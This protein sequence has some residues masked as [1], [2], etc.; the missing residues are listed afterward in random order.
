MSH[1]DCSIVYYFLFEMDSCSVAQAGVQW[2]DLSSLQPL[3]PRFKRFSCLSRLRVGFHHVGLAGLELLTSSDLPALASQS[4][5][6]T[7]G[8]S[9]IARLECSGAIRL[10]ALRFSVQAISCLSL[11]MESPSVSQAGVQWPILA[12]C[13][14]LLPGSSN[15]PASASQVAGITGVCHH[16]W[17][18]FVILVETGFHHIG[19]DGRELLTS[20]N[21]PALASQSAGITGVN[22]CTRPV[23]TFCFANFFTHDKGYNISVHIN[24]IQGLFLSPRLEYRGTI[25]A[26]GS[27]DFPGSSDPPTSASQMRS[28][29]IVQAGLELLG[30]S[31]C[32]A[33]ASQSAGI[34]GE[35]TQLRRPAV[36]HP[37]VDP[38]S[39]GSGRRQSPLRHRHFFRTPQ[40][41]PV[42][43]P[44]L[45]APCQL[46]SR[47]LEYV[48]K[49]ERVLRGLVHVA[50]GAAAYVSV[51]WRADAQ[52]CH[53]PAVHELAPSSRM[54]TPSG[55]GLGE[56]VGAPGDQHSHSIP[57]LECS[58][59]L[60]SLLPLL[61]RLKRFSCLSLLRSTCL[62]AQLIFVFLVETEFLHVGQTGL[63]L[64]TSG[65]P[66]SPASQS[67]SQT[68]IPLHDLDLLQPLHPGFKLF[69]CLSLPINSWLI[70][71]FFVEM[72]SG[73]ISEVGLKLLGSSNPPASA[74]QNA[75]IT[76]I[77]H[78]A[79]N[80]ISF[81][82]VFTIMNNMLIN[83]LSFFLFFETES[84]SVAQA[85]VEWH[86]LGS[87]QPPP[88]R[89][90][91]FSCLSLPSN[92]DYRHSPP[93]LAIFVFL[94]ETGFHHVGQ[95]GLKLLT[96]GHLPASV[97]QNAG[98][99]TLLLA[100][101][102]EKECKP[103]WELD[104]M[105]TGTGW[106]LLSGESRFCAGLTAASKP[107]PSWNLDSR[108]VSRKNQSPALSARLQCS[109]V[110][111]AHCSLHLPGSSD[112]PVSA[113]QVVATTMPGRVLY[114]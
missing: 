110:F 65:D 92:W 79:Y 87:L 60:G 52:G 78:R 109:G 101:P 54:R 73:G 12:H 2:H 99:Q 31:N 7:D 14:L 104:R 94:V 19:Q 25:M 81:V 32:P 103:V 100:T 80:E 55:A 83:F 108:L 75:G 61:P 35:N 62:H 1:H 30:S 18:I 76:V 107:L 82:W 45:L 6:I 20:G 24:L 95:S 13:N 59:D 91:Q 46:G 39:S 17:L 64:L 72:G 66:L 16:A 90:K 28:Y 50:E 69:S 68:G 88:S 15:S 29:Y 63:K 36:N 89:F 34:K 112:S 10:T 42:R 3:P 56:G 86:Y 26:H 9:L 37:Q 98:L 53:L 44:S 111:S 40:P 102:C 49:Q 70:F 51:Q 41:F 84:H 106:S 48:Q 85:R 77:S 97:S 113:S 5:E 93:C 71:N 74:S 11:R 57:R 27:L 67:A 22:H 8:V 4:A 105:N 96:S 47:C 38:A 58:G 43:T 21:L 33:L 114:V 23:K